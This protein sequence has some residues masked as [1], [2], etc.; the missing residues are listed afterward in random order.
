MNKPAVWKLAVG[1]TILLLGATV[2]ACQGPAGPEG[3]EGPA[4]PP[5]P[6]GA[7]GPPGE[8]AEAAAAAAGPE[9][10]GSETCS[11]CHADIYN[12]F[13]QSGHPYE[14][15]KVVDGQPPEYPF[16]KVAE[17]PQGYSWDDILYVIGGYGWKAHFI[18]QE[19]YI[20]T[21]DAGASTQ[22]N[23]Y[24]VKLD[25]GDDWAAYHAGEETPYDCGACHT[26][27]YSDWPSDSHQ[28]DLPGLIG[29]WALDG[30]QC[31]AC[32][33]PASLHVANVGNEALRPKV[34]R[35]SEMCER[36]H[37]RSDV[38]EID[39]SGLFI[40]RHEQY[41]EFF[42]GKHRTLDCVDC[43]DP[44][45]TTHYRYQADVSGMRIECQNCHWEQAQ[46]FPEGHVVP[47][48]IDCHMAGVAK[49]AVASEELM[50][51][52]FANH[53]FAINPYAE[54]QFY[55]NDEGNTFS[56]DFI[57]LPYACTYCHSE[58]GFASPKTT[59]ELMAFAQG[60]HD[61]ER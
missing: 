40:Q 51:G 42:Q 9:Y 32:H 47:T 56:Q 17:P 41:E 21:G 11:E 4:G 50:R 29:T 38:T 43:H 39:A 54:E 24:N 55:T 52:D 6:Q 7:A 48:C 61:R 57:T 15:N 37:V 20:I 27:G 23:L 36:C 3:P 58:A 1:M 45:A 34:T 53:L 28:D 60:Y 12:S 19:G 59:E 14:L 18:D 2:V 33:G 8:V 26:T 22:Y 46:F 13:M 35:D 25:L 16:S 44:H 30:V 49:S 5:G 31:E 10:V